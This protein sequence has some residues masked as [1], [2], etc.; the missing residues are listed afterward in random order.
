[1]GF[2]D[3]GNRGTIGEAHW[4]VRREDKGEIAGCFK[5]GE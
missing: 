4:V 1:M 2:S 5:L 3:T